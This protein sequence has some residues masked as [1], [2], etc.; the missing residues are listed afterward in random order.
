[1]LRRWFVG[2]TSM[3]PG[4]H[5]ARHS[6]KI[7]DVNA[8]YKTAISLVARLPPPWE[9][10]KRGRRPK[11]SSRQYLAVCVVYVCL[12][13]TYRE[14]E[15]LGPSFLKKTVDHSTVGKAF[16]R[17]KP[18]YVKLVLGLL[19]KRLKGH[20]EFDFY[21]IDSTGISTPRLKTRVRALKKVR[22]RENLKLHVLAGYSSKASA[23]V[24][25]AARVTKHNVTDGSQVGYL[26]RGIDGGGKRLLGDSA[27][28]WRRNIELALKRGFKPLF[29]PRDLEY[30]GMFR[31]IV[32]RD[33]KRNRK[34]YKQRGIGEAIFGGI[35]NRYG[36]HTRCKR[37]R[38]KVLSMLLMLVAH[39]LRTYMRV[40][41]AEKRGFLFVIW[42][43][44]T[45]PPTIRV[46]STATRKRD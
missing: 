1:M 14:I 44:L 31:K 9:K 16:K 23:L 34:L 10:S 27:Y 19:R 24:I 33:F 45:S 6:A 12:D 5:A 32:L 11:L 36:A 41:A 46:V 21:F 30:H 8:V 42:I 29:K 28:D 39:N 18:S 37:V 25:V 20:A 13:L 15:G 35:E 7:Y 38:T 2:R 4:Y 40:R 26:T 17:L 3:H 43:Y 22:E